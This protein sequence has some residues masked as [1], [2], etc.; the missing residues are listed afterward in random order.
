[1]SRT[2]DKDRADDVNGRFS[3]VMVLSYQAAT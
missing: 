3:A 1:M 2:D